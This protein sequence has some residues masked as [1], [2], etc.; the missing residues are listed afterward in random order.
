MLLL[1]QLI[2]DVTVVVTDAV[3][4][5]LCFCVLLLL[6]AGDSH[7]LRLA[8]DAKATLQSSLMILAAASC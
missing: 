5:C 1:L 4:C 2:A 7:D 8:T 3:F 6:V